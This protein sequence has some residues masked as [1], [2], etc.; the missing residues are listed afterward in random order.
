MTLQVQSPI[1]QNKILLEN[2]SLLVTNTIQ[3]V[4]DL[5]IFMEHHVYAVWDFMSLAKSLQHSVCP[6]GNLWL[7]SRVQR[8]CSRFINEIILNEESDNDPF[9]GYTT[10]HFDLYCQAMVEIGADISK[11]LNFIKIVEKNGINEALESADIPE[12]SRKFVR[13]TFDIIDSNKPSEIAAAFT[14]GRETVIPNMF[15]RLMQQF[16]FNRID[17]P[18][19]FYYL[20]R[21]ITVDAE[22]H[23]PAALML[24]K[25][26]CE[27]DPIKILE[28][29]KV[30]VKAIQS[31][32]EFW[33][34]VEQVICNT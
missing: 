33:N 12:P 18:R 34:E 25:E 10:S 17:C 23:G 4:E 24:I 31:R 19:M 21:H 1:E 11:I 15:V 8:S 14:Y 32:I 27:N 28:A 30:A 6:S 5:R 16:D 9:S 20:D 13:S 29:E 22:D 2:H 3:S 26:L 7:P